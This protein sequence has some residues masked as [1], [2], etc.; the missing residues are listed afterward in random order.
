MV[1]LNYVTWHHFVSPLGPPFVSRDIDQT[2]DNFLT[3]YRKSVV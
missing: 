3:N 1:D 2:A